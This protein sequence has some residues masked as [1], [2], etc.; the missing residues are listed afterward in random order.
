MGIKD[1]YYTA[2]EVAAVLKVSRQ[3]VYRWQKDHKLPYEMIGSLTLFPRASIDSL[4]DKVRC[5]EC[6]HLKPFEGIK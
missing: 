5:S 4:A 3:T 1:E 6:G 2:T